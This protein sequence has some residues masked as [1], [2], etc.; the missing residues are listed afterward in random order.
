M[1]APKKPKKKFTRKQWLVSAI[2]VA[3]FGIWAVLD[4]SKHDEQAEQLMDHVVA[5]GQ[6]EGSPA[7]FDAKAATYTVL[8][9]GKHLSDGR[10]NDPADYLVCTASLHNGKRARM[11]GIDQEHAVKGASVDSVGVFTAVAG[12]TSVACAEDAE[13]DTLYVAQAVAR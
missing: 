4:T 3:A 8:V 11:E 5:K 6:V 10:N 13:G 2:V 1:D 9:D 7:H 12:A